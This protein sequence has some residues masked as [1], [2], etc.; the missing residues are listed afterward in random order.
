MNAEQTP[1]SWVERWDRQQELYVP[2]REARFAVMFDALDALTELEGFTSAPT[3][4]DLACGPGA[5]GERL[6]RH[7]PEAQCTGVDIDPVLLHLARVVAQPFGDQFRI[8]ERDLAT[9]TWASTFADN[10]FDV[11]TSS[12]AL[13]W[14]DAEELRNVLAECA[15]ILRPGGLFFNADNLSFPTTQPGLQRIASHIDDGHQV[16]AAAGGTETWK[17]WWDSARLDA[18]L[19]QLC[20]ARDLRFPPAAD[21]ESPPPSLDL[22]IT[23]L[24]ECGFIEAATIWQRF[25]DRV[26]MARLPGTVHAGDGE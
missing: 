3:V 17:Q 24:G 2:F 14:L 25:D 21:A 18:E 16:N 13:H 22:Y 23:L 15:R 5:I 9:A 7:R 12:T 4:L 8:E 20:E 11:V 26:V 10:S 1:S 6:L 19:R